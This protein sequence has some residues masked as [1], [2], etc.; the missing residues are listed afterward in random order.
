MDMCHG[1]LG[2]QII[3]FTIPLVLTGLLQTFFHA[4]DLM[5]VGRFASHKALAA[6]GATTS[7]TWL[8]INVFIGL[9]VGTNVMVARYLG[10]KNRKEV[11]RSVHTSVYIS[12]AGGIFLA[13]FGILCSKFFL[14][15]LGT[16][17]DILNMATLYMQIY[18]AGMPII[19]LYN[20]GS[21][22]LRA[23]GDTQRP[24]Y[25][26]IIGGIINVLLNLFFVIV[27]KMDV[28]GVAIATVISQ[29]VSVWL[30]LNVMYK[31][32]EGC[33]FTWKN[34]RITRKNLK[35]IMWIGIPTGIQG[36]CF[37]F[38]NIIIQSSINKFGTDAIAGNTAAWQWEGLFF[39]AF[40]SLGTSVVSF[41]SQNL[42]GKQYKRITRSVNYCSFLAVGFAV[43]MTI[44]LF[45]FK[46]QSLA[47]F[48]KNPEVIEWGYTRFNILLPFIWAGG[49]MEVYI[50]GI[51]GMGYSITPSI[52]MVL[53]ACV[54]RI[55]WVFTFFK[56]SPTMPMLLWSY[57]ISWV[58]IAAVTGVYFLMIIKKHHITN[59]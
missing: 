58:L 12:L 22:I 54:F 56:M 17:D 41:V 28:A 5:V 14:K 13:L 55:A 31:M 52:I 6:V 44:M 33:R 57:P 53:G 20:F 47:I 46:E 19:M 37:S 4:A 24:F 34:L 48:N 32:Q 9:S 36:A 11:S 29:A 59:K 51:R 26:L 42:G 21:A 27:C 15:L 49:L 45:I 1:P 2:R 50:G 7:L 39:V 16:P 23:A 38:S 35:E 8:M 25:F 10:G 30:M 40:M 43:F 18:F 3:V